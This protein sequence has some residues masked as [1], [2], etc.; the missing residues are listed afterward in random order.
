MGF[1]YLM[2]GVCSLRGNCEKKGDL[3]NFMGGGGSS[4]V[5]GKAHFSG[6][7]RDGRRLLN[8]GR[9]L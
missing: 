6:G 2:R 4:Q 8:L 5:Q 3:R 1:R 9:H 7:V